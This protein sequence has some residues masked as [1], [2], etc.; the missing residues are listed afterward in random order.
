MKHTTMTPL[1][2]LTGFTAVMAFLISPLTINSQMAP[3]GGVPATPEAALAAVK[4]AN[5]VLLQK[6]QA[7]LD[8]LDALQKEADQL[9]IYSKRG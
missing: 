9:R 5:E 4:T 2:A 7:T 8:K 1:A 3:A 6:Q